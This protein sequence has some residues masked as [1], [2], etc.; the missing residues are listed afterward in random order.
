MV[1]MEWSLLNIFEWRVNLFSRSV[2]SEFALSMFYK[3][4][5]WTGNHKRGIL[6]E[7]KFLVAFQCELSENVRYFM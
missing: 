2:S 1:V 3:S 7:L 4:S 6:L 5:K